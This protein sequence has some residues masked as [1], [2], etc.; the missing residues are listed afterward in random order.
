[1][2]AFRQTRLYIGTYSCRS[3]MAPKPSSSSKGLKP[4]AQQQKKKRSKESA[5]IKAGKSNLKGLGA[6]TKV[7]ES[8]MP[9]HCFAAKSL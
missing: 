7:R 6:A 8:R 9:H 2:R 4:S 3:Q 5:K 1:M